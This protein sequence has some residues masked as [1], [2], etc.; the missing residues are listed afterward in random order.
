MNNSSERII[1]TMPIMSIYKIICG[2]HNE[3]NE[4]ITRNEIEQIENYI[5]GVFSTDMINICAMRPADVFRKL[6]IQIN[7]LFILFEKGFSSFGIDISSDYKDIV[8]CEYSKLRI[9]TTKENLCTLNIKAHNNDYKYLV[10][11][12]EFSGDFSAYYTNLWFD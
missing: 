6:N 2:D 4:N 8:R 3:L 1:D 11:K 7:H 5:E 10:D 12:L 9:Y